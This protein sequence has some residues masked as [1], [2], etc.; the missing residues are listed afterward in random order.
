MARLIFSTALKLHSNMTDQCYHCGLPVAEKSDFT[1][2]IGNL[3]RAM[4]CPGCAAVASTIT[5]SGLENFYSFRTEQLRQPAPERAQFSD[6]DIPALQNDYVSLDTQGPAQQVVRRIRVHIGNI[7]CAACVWLIEKQLEKLSGIEQVLI[8][9]TTHCGEIAWNPERL[10]LSTILGAMADIGYLVTPINNQSQ[11]PD[12]SSQNR[13]MLLR[14]G[15][16]GLAMMQTTMVS[17]ALYAGALQGIEPQW[18]Y[19]LRLVSAILVTP[20]VFYSAQPFFINAWR[21]LRLGHLVMDVPVAL[22]IGLAYSASLWATWQG[23]GEVYFDSVAMF[24]FFLLLGRFAEQRIR[25]RNLLSVHVQGPLLPPAATKILSANGLNRFETVPIKTLQLGD[26]ISVEAGQTIPCDGTIKKGISQISEAVLTGESRAVPK[27]AGQTVCAGTVNGANPLVIKVS[28]IGGQTRLSTILELAERA[29]L[30]KPY[31]ASLA[32]R[33]AGWF[34]SAVLLIATAVGIFWSFYD[35]SRALW[36]TLSVLVVTCPCALSLATPTVLALANSLLRGQGFLINRGHVLEQLSK[37]DQV[38][39]DKTGTL[40]EGNL[41]LT[42]V[43]PAAAILQSHL[44]QAVIWAASLEQGSAHPIARALQKSGLPLVTD[45]QFVTGCGVLGKLA[46]NKGVLQEFAFGSPPWVAEVMGLDRQPQLKTDYGIQVAL[47]CK[48]E[49]RGQERSEW[50]ASLLFDDQLR[51]SAETTVRQLDEQGIQAHLLSGDP[52]P[53][54]AEIVHNLQLRS[55]AFGLQPQ[56]KLAALKRLQAQHHQVL[57]VGDGINDIP[58]LQAADISVAMGAASELSQISADAILLNN[59]LEMLP[60]AISLAHRARH[61]IR[62]NIAWAIGYNALALP[63]AAMGHVPP[64]A[65]AIGMSASSLL[66]VVNALRLKKTQPKST[67]T[68][69]GLAHV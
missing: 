66:V 19:L 15:V 50:I 22:A 52:S 24:A 60:K 64:W 46:N 38:I 12:L 31:W 2:V 16:A 69:S 30:E 23:E 48:R 37:V 40:T 44:K 63:L 28:A 10:K 39:F 9:G 65:A 25:Y 21:S 4:C 33:V 59:D 35:P 58:I 67:P 45:Q 13:K 17:I 43:I 55:M 20:V 57:M 61:I 32:D 36:V 47:A 62:Q 68:I 11:L 1:V 18:Q 53:A 14:L 7:S 8:N 6:W 54:A 42:K 26:L 41:L 29:A 56:H 51:G 27:Q 49:W 34:V 3:P 5:G